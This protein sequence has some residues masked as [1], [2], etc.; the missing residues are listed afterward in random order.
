MVAPDIVVEEWAKTFF[1]IPTVELVD[2]IFEHGSFVRAHAETYFGLPRN[3]FDAMAKQMDTVKIFTRWENNSRVIN[4][5]MSR[6]DVMSIF[7]KSSDNELRP[8]FRKVTDSSF[9]SMPSMPE[10]IE[11]NSPSLDTGFT[12]RPLNREICMD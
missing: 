10:I 7:E 9:S 4:P 12:I 6:A 11:R 5:D 3:K 1:G 2:Y 8:L